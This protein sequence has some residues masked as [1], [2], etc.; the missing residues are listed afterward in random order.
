MALAIVLLSCLRDVEDLLSE[1]GI[2]V[3]Y[4]AIRLW[5]R[6]FGPGYAR[7]LRR[8]RGRSGDSWFLDGLFVTIRGERHY[9]WR[10]VDQDGDT[11]DIFSALPI[12]ASFETASS[13]PGIR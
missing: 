5:C 6:K 2:L 9:L 3:S 10:A 7:Y 12:N 13:T 1:R 8:N 11:V 4:E